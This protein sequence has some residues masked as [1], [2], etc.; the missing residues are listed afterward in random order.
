MITG[1]LGRCVGC[2]RFAPLRGPRND[3]C[4]RCLRICTL[5]F[6][7]LAARVR[8]EPDFALACYRQLPE[9]WRHKFEITFGIPPGC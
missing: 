6:L 3:A 1:Y 5:R 8:R 7:E 2:N 9:P 4:A